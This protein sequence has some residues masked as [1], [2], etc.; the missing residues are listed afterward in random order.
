MAT[1]YFRFSILLILSTHSLFAQF[2]NLDV[3]Y[4]AHSSFFG[5]IRENFHLHLNKTTYVPG[6]S[7]WFKAY[8][9]EQNSQ[10]P[11]LG[12]SNL[13]VGLYDEKG[14]EVKKKLIYLEDG[15]GY[16]QFKIDSVLAD[17]V[18]YIKAYTNW[19]KNFVHNNSFVEKIILK[20]SAESPY[21]NK[22]NTEELAIELY[23]ESGHI[24]TDAK[25]TVA[26]HVGGS[27]SSASVNN[28]QLLDQNGEVVLSDI[29]YNSS[30]YGKFTFYQTSKEPFLL[31]AELSNGKSLEKSLPDPKRNG[32][33]WSVNNLDNRSPIVEISTNK[34]TLATQQSDIYYLAI[35][36]NE[37]LTVEPIRLSNTLQ[38]LRIP[39]E[40]L[41]PGI[42]TVTLFNA[43]YLPMA[44]RLVFRWPENRVA[45][46]ETLGASKVGKDSIQ[47]NLMIQHPDTAKYSLSISALPAAQS[48]NNPSNSILSSY[49]LMP[50]VR[51]PIKDPASY[52]QKWDRLK[53][54]ELD[55]YLITEGWGKYNWDIIF[56]NETRDDFEWESLISVEGLVLDADLAEEDKVWLYTERTEDIIYSDLKR[57]KTFQTFSRLYRGDSLNV[58]VG[59][60]KGR[61]RQP[62]AELSFGP[63]VL[64]GSMS[65][66]ERAQIY[67]ESEDAEKQ[68]QIPHS[69][70]IEGPPLVQPQKII[71]L[72]EV[73]L[74]EEKKVE[75]RMQNQFVVAADTEARIISEEDIE[76]RK[77]LRN[78]LVRLGFKIT[79]QG[80]QLIVLPRIPDPRRATVAVYLD[81][82]FVEDG[83]DIFNMPLTRV[84]SLSFDPRRSEFISINTRFEPYKKK[85]SEFIR[86]LIT[87]GYDRPENYQ[88]P[89][90]NYSDLTAFELYGALDWTPEIIVDSNTPFTYQVPNEDLESI[91]LFIEGMGSDGTLISTTKVLQLKENE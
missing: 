85:S 3:I 82:M 71:E 89:I 57:D 81:G 17:S 39:K 66:D 49:W 87:N 64:P 13:R 32:V 8:V 22:D 7:I 27:N 80:S 20:K 52:F 30:G 68:N 74:V 4:K 25:N 62:K 16:G 36:K 29:E 44:R 59:G 28:I 75:N 77:T 43:D 70:A 60:S 61:L 50:Y 73:E 15:T 41:Q 46:L 83:F 37:Y 19:M 58:S 54:Y 14:Q 86:F 45:P 55:V 53:S 38:T 2:N 18:Y 48:S 88:N 76:V 79:L 35:H 24:L 56:N 1:N 40:A 42:N 72:D 21:Q 51:N 23:P 63:P 6:E 84:R 34:A 33:V 10:T 26:F 69:D 9:L 65:S 67:N 31:Y 90:Y 47:V 91:T 11:S 5:P 78:Y 12:T